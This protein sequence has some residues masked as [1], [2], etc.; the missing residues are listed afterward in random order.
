MSEENKV[1]YPTKYDPNYHPKKVVGYC[2]L[3]LTDEQMAGIFEIDVATFYRWKNKHSEFCE[4][5]KSGKEDADVK[6]AAS[7][8]KRASGHKEKRIIPIK[9]RTTVNGEGSTEKVEMVE[10]EDYY[11]PEVAAQIF[12]LKN[13]NPQMWRDKKEIELNDASNIT[14]VTLIDD[15]DENEDSQ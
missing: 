3:G 2:L 5:I 12:W 8:F 14:G 6:I 7:L 11:P 10:V 4:A 15:D 1:G 13:R 9:L